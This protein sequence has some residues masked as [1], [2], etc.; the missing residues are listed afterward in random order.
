M[1]RNIAAKLEYYEN[2]LKD[3][4]IKSYKTQYGIMAI[5][6]GGSARVICKM[7]IEVNENNAVIGH[8][9]STSGGRIEN[10]SPEEVIERFRSAR[11]ELA[12]VLA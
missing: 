9:D 8:Y 2:L 10:A 4:N 11:L 12:E 7:D 6:E 5:M 1:D 3:L